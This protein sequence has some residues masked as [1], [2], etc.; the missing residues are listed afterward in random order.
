MILSSLSGYW[1]MAKFYIGLQ[2][3]DDNQYVNFTFKVLDYDTG[4]VVGAWGLDTYNWVTQGFSEHGSVTGYVPDEFE[5]T[6][7]INNVDSYEQC[8]DISGYSYYV[9]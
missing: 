2:G 8:F 6:A 4:Q 3:G 9:S 1:W 5:V 7:Q